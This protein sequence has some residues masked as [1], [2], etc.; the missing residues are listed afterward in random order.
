MVT[1]TSNRT[2]APN[3]PAPPPPTVS[4][5]SNFSWML[6]GNAVYGGCQW[7]VVVV[8]ARLGTSSM[9]GQYVFALALTAPVMAFFMMQLRAVQAT[10]ANRTFE[11]GHYLALRLAMMCLALVMLG[12]WCAAC[13]YS[14]D[15]TLVIAAVAVLAV[16]D[17]LTDVIYGLLQQHERLDAIAQSMIL[18]GVAT[19]GALVVT[20]RATGLLYLGILA[21]AAVRLLVLGLFDVPNGRRILR[22]GWSFAID[23]RG[24]VG[25]AM[26]PR[27]EFGK[28]VHLARLSLPLGVVMTL[29][30]LN[31][32]IP[33][34]FVER[35]LDKSA[36]GIFGAICQ[37]TLA[38]S[39]A[40]C[41]LGESISPRLARFYAQLEMRA[42]ARLFAQMTG[43]VLGLG[44]AG[45]V[46][47]ICAGPFLLGVLY[48]PVYA[49]HNDLLVLT[50]I[51][52]A[53]GYAG[54]LG[55]YALTA[56]RYFRSQ[57]PLLALV[58]GVGVLACW[59]LIPIQGLLG[60]AI[61]LTVSAL[62]QVVGA[63]I[64]LVHALRPR[65]R[66]IDEP[67]CS[68]SGHADGL[69]GRMQLPA[70]ATRTTT[71]EV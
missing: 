44:G 20:M 39:L 53:V 48:G 9:V 66:A 57:I 65:S 47:A 28:L 52:A 26:V 55:G 23:A 34:F 5:R 56:A 15:T 54:L 3:A 14:G 6:A 59:W 61:A 33:R 29:L 21:I 18:R 46:V 60:G 19:L 38:G 1:G 70:E 41:A 43:L 27:W 25:R 31:S 10:D 37:L 63:G 35:Y 49:A 12:A 58:A 36:L 50:M 13:G 67:P 69:P 22:S 8:L 32:S 51:A 16:T 11:F 42:F 68:L 17:S 40:V 64:L 71:L 24:G 30:I 4:L 2:A 7:A 45:I 62:T